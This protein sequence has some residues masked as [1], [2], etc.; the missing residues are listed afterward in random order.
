METTTKSERQITRERIAT[1]LSK[2]ENCYPHT[3]LQISGQQ[4]VCSDGVTAQD[5]FSSAL[6]SLEQLVKALGR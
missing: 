5:H 1:A 4:I 2:L 6:R 3:L